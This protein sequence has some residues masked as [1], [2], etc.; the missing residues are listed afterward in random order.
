MKISIGQ[1]VKRAGLGD[2]PRK[3]FD[4]IARI[5]VVDIVI[6]TRHGIEIR[7]RC[8]AQ[9]DKAQAI[10]LQRLNLHLPQRLKISKM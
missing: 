4:E 2:E 10:L 8:I 9:P 7:K 6:Y 5:K 3:V 1:K